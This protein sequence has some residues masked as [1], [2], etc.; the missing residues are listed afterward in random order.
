[1]ETTFTCSY[2]YSDIFKYFIKLNYFRNFPPGVN[3]SNFRKKLRQ[4]AAFY[5][6]DVDYNVEDL[7]M[8]QT[9]LTFNN[10]DVEITGQRLS[11]TCEEVVLRFDFFKGQCTNWLI[12]HRRSFDL[13]C[14]FLTRFSKKK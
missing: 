4:L 5:S 13:T 14:H 11:P 2:V 7:K 10:L 3:V 1:M 8:L 6:P 9:V 12:I